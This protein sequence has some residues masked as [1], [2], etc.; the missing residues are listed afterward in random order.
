MLNR[1]L[2]MVS[3]ICKIGTLVCKDER[4]YTVGGGGSTEL[5]ALVGYDL[6]AIYFEITTLYFKPICRIQIN[7]TVLW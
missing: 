4:S 2:N 6:F 1:C 3:K 7:Y 5:K